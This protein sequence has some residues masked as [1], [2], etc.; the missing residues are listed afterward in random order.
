[1]DDM[2]RVDATSAVDCNNGLLGDHAVNT[3]SG[4]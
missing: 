1:V 4:F 3:Q 2:W